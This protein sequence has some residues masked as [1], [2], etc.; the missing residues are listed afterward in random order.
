MFMSNQ[1]F[2]IGKWNGYLYDF[3]Q[4]NSRKIAYSA[5]ALY[6]ASKGINAISDYLS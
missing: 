6:C 3:A 4:N 5:V 1:T 2:N